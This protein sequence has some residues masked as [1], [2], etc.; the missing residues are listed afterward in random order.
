MQEWEKIMDE[1]FGYDNVI[2]L[3]TSENDRPYV[4]SVNAY[5]ESGSFYIITYALSDKMKQLEKN[6]TAAI[7]GEWFTAHGTS[8]N[9]GFIGKEENRPTAE[10]L[11]AVFAE[12][13]DNGHVDFSAETTIIL[14]I[15]L[16]DGILFSEGKRFDI[17]FTKA[18]E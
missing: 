12:W 11:R 9:M 6:P 14:R 13:I 17:D 4:R 1:R 3:A 15:K 18:Y 5:Y 10:K 16:T 7:S 8:E 2:A